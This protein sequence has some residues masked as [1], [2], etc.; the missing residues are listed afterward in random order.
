[1][2]PLKDQPLMIRFIGGFLLGTGFVF[3]K[4]KKGE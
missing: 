4:G 3:L 1:V 2:G